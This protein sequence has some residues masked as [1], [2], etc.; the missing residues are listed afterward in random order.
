MNR[1]GAA[2]DF[3][4]DRGFTFCILHRR[5]ERDEAWRR[6]GARRSLNLPRLILLPPSPLSAVLVLSLKKCATIGGPAPSF[7]QR[8]PRGRRSPI[9][10]R[11]GEPKVHVKAGRTENLEPL[12]R[13]S[14][15]RRI[16]RLAHTYIANSCRCAPPPK[17][18]KDCKYLIT[19]S[20]LG[21]TPHTDGSPSAFT[22]TYLREPWSKHIASMERLVCSS[23]LCASAP[24]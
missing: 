14:R 9:L 3:H 2:S 17:P 7:A 19:S 4:P 6:A 8:H 18:K 11:G 20:L 12:S 22:G 24:A 16:A 1:S 23:F 21:H 15:E 13:R 5:L 10:E